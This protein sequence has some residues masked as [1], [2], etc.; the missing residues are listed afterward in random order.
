[1]YILSQVQ[2]IFLSPIKKENHA[3]IQYICLCLQYMLYVASSFVGHVEKRRLI[4]YMHMPWCIMITANSHSFV[5]C[6]CMFVVDED[7][8]TTANS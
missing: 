2:Q 4:Y 8:I 6:I 5:Y 3:D 1:M 7:P